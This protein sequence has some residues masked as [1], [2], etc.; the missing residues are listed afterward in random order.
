[1]IL[2]GITGVLVLLLVHLHTLCLGGSFYY[3]VDHVYLGVYLQKRLHFLL[4]TVPWAVVSER[5]PT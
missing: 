1:M 2:S 3:V 5:V 4:V